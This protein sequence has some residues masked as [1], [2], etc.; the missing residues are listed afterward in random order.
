MEQNI[1]IATQ[2]K[3]KKELAVKQAKLVLEQAESD[4]KIADFELEFLKRTGKIGEIFWRFPHIG[5]KLFEKISAEQVKKCK[6][7]YKWWGNFINEQKIL[8]LRL[9][10][11]HICYPLVKKLQ[12]YDSKILQL[13]A[14]YCVKNQHL[15]NTKFDP[16]YQNNSNCKEFN[17][18]QLITS[19]N[20]KED[21]EL[22]KLLI[23]K[24]NVKNPKDTKGCSLLHRAAIHRSMEHKS[25][26]LFYILIDTFIS[27][28]H[29]GLPY[30]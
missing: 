28:P 9:L 14:N 7:V 30:N 12:H 18:L 22:S 23:E 29:I 19:Y 21:V 13:L 3:L 17:I 4:L 15:R 2:N 25:A 6:T 11:N 1:N 26:N 16:L 27:A 20:K 5:R 10:R 24:M 8:P